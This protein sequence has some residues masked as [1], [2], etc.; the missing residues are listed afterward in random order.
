MR[1]REAYADA[2]ARRAQK[3]GETYDGW[4]D[5]NNYVRGPRQTGWKREPK[6]YWSDD[7]LLAWIG[8]CSHG[9]CKAEMHSVGGAEPT[10][11]CLNA[12][13]PWGIEGPPAEKS[14]VEKRFAG[15]DF[16]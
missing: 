14:H 1:Q 10:R 16:S 15:L 12:D 7:P 4:G 6:S 8:A 5:A 9:S 13:C 3:S 2:R 11:V